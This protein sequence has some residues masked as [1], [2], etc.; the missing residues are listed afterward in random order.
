MGERQIVIYVPDVELQLIEIKFLSEERM[1]CASEMQYFV[2]VEVCNNGFFLVYQYRYQ[3][4]C[5]AIPA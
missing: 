5:G 1:Q 2:W 4:L 3:Y